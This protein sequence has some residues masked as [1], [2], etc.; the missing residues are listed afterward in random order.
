MK[1]D[2]G[3]TEAAQRGQAPVRTRMH[4]ELQ[5]DGTT[6]PQQPGEW[7]QVF[8]WTNFSCHTCLWVSSATALRY[9]RYE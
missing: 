8:D 7:P 2:F 3:I 1:H 4:R 6:W 9:L 5:I